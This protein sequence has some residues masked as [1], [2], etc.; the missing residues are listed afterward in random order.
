MSKSTEGSQKTISD[1]TSKYVEGI[2]E[3]RFDAFLSDLRSGEYQQG[4]DRLESNGKFCCLGIACIRPAAEGVVTR[5]TNE[6]GAVYY[7]ETSVDLPAS[8]ADY[9]G[10]PLTHRVDRAGT[11]SNIAFYKQGYYSDNPDGMVQT[12]VGWNDSLG[13]SFAEIADAFE[14]EFLKLEFLKDES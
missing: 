2:N 4:P 11:S 13:K 1:G 8:V 10:I 14:L 6:W 3:E 12:A 5:E 7:G 9:L